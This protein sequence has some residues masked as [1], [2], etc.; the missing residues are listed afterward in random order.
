MEKQIHRKTATFRYNTEEDKRLCRRFVN[1]YL[2]PDGVFM[3]RLLSKN[4]NSIIVSE[5]VAAL[6]DNYKKKHVGLRSNL[7]SNPH[8]TGGGNSGDMNPNIMNSSLM[9]NGGINQGYNSAQC[10]FNTA[11]SLHSRNSTAAA[12]TFFDHS[13][14]P[15]TLPFSKPKITQMF[16]QSNN[17]N[18]VNQQNM[19]SAPSYSFATS[20]GVMTGTQARKQIEALSSTA[21]NDILD[22]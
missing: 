9:V 4:T 16:T 10:P 13:K 8:H 15:T 21:N 18:A 22:V 7:V 19:F 12:A 3:I 5:L 11:G 17:A 14:M 6:W 20:G 2:R 1:V